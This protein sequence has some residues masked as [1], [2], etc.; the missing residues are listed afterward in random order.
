MTVSLSVLLVLSLV[1]IWLLYQ[2][3]KTSFYKI[4]TDSTETEN[5]IRNFVRNENSSILSST[6]KI[7]LEYSDNFDFSIIIHCNAKT[8]KESIDQVREVRDILSS[9]GFDKERTEV[10]YIIHHRNPLSK[11]F[12]EIS[13]SIKHIRFLQET[14]DQLKL[15]RICLLICR[16]KYLIDA[17]VI[18]NELS[19]FTTYDENFIVIGEPSKRSSVPYYDPLTYSYPVFASKG[20]AML[21][22]MRLHLRGTKSTSELIYIA[23]RLHVSV[24][25]KKYN[26]RIKEIGIIQPLYYNIVKRIH[27]PLFKYNIWT[28]NKTSS[29]TDQII[30]TIKK[31][32]KFNDDKND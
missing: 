24:Y 2:F 31:K 1:L 19:S 7:N 26:I 3:V 18:E 8:V 5:D 32:L 17:Q 13:M 22:F 16:G 14:D 28:I 10:I 25:I 4:F 11:R 30:N 27:I 9:Y 15:F 20:S 6:N 12:K 21:I 23:Q 29:F